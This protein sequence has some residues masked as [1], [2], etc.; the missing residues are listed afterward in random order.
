MVAAIS[1][2]N[3]EAEAYFAMTPAWHGLGTVVQKAATS[4]EAMRLAHLNWTVEKQEISTSAGL[5]IRDKMATV[6]TDINRVLGVVG[7][8]YE[9]IQNHEAFDF[10]DGLLQDGLMKYESAGALFGGRVIWVLARMPSV[11]QVA[12]GDNVMRFA[13]FAT[14]HD[15]SMAIHAIPTATRVVCANTLRIATAGL[16]GIRHTASA[17]DKLEV[18]KRYLSQFDEKFTLFRDTARVLATTRWNNQQ[19][20]DYIEKLFPT[21]KEKDGTIRDKK[22]N[23]VRKAML[24]ER[25][26][27]PAIKGTWWQLFNAVTE[28][29]DHAD[30]PSDKKASAAK[31]AERKEKR[32][33]SLMDGTGAEFKAKAFDLAVSM[34]A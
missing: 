5:K 32:M 12:E 13:L 2:V 20:I 4:E 11:D 9:L 22:V 25:N 17:R 18:A 8:G 31:L 10:L 14:G 6:R 21:P 29:I 19:A 30:H 7:T 28:T 24:N 26:A 27:M 1:V 23:A 34:S 16:A 3:G 33:L 15:G